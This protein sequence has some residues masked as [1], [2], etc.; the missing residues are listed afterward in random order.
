MATHSS[1]NSYKIAMVG[2]LKKVV[3]GSAVSSKTPS[4]IA[5]F[6][7][8]HHQVRMLTG[9]MHNDSSLVN[10]IFSFHRIMI[11]V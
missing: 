1:H 3:K 11:Y 5:N 9:Q 7:S 10:V 8:D 4:L 6:P 2:L